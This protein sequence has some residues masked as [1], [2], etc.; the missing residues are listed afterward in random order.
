MNTEE[1]KQ[2]MSHKQYNEVPMD[3]ILNTP[4]AIEFYLKYH[5]NTLEDYLKVNLLELFTKEHID[6]K[7]IYQIE[8]QLQQY[9]NQNIQPKQLIPF[10]TIYLT[11]V[12]YVSDILNSLSWCGI[13][14]LSDLCNENKKDLL[15]IFKGNQI[16]LEECIREIK[17]YLETSK[18]LQHTNAKEQL[19]YLETYKRLCISNE[20]VLQMKKRLL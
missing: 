2:L 4:L 12:I 9:I 15:K 18:R 3:E 6:F 13:H 8:Q 11:D 10:S 17:I 1:I 19:Y 20:N 16:Y 5:I 7:I 14:T